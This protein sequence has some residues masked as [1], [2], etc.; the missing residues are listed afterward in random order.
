MDTS[1]IQQAIDEIESF[2]L[3]CLKN[4]HTDVGEV[5]DHFNSVS[6]LLRESIIQTRTA[7]AT[8]DKHY[9]KLHDGLSDMIEGGRLKAS[10][11]PDDYQWLIETLAAA[12]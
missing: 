2:N 8:N 3:E 4:E 5:W 7:P 1:L 12:Q 11:I 10:D 6:D 9:H